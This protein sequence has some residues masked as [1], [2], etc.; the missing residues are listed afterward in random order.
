VQADTHHANFVRAVRSRNASELNC[1]VREGELSS[2]LCHLAG[3]SHR[4]GAPV[5]PDAIRE[6]VKA[7]AHAVEA[8]GRLGEHLKRN[9]ALPDNAVFGVPLRID[10]AKEVIVDNP[11]ASELA[12]RKDRAP[13]TVPTLV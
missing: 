1:N 9:D 7:D 8:L 6:R 5:A 10:T 4:L 13:F 11:A 2:A 3:I 12:R